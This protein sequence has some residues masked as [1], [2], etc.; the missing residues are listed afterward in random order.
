[1]DT[2]VCGPIPGPIAYLIAGRPQFENEESDSYKKYLKQVYIIK[3][4][5]ILCDYGDE[6]LH[7]GLNTISLW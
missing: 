3:N 1:M 7:A 2:D 4:S 6:Y 5:E